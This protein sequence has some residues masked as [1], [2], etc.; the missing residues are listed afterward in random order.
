MKKTPVILFIKLFLLALP[1]ILS[2]TLVFYFTP[3]PLTRR[4]Q[5]FTDKLE[6]L[7]A[8]TPNVPPVIFAGDSRVWKGLIPGLFADIS[9]VGA[10]NIATGGGTLRQFYR[11]MKNSPALM[12]HRLLVINVNAEQVDKIKGEPIEGDYDIGDKE[13]IL[14]KPLSWSKIVDIVN[15]AD[16]LRQYYLM[17][18]RAFV[19]GKDIGRLPDQKKEF[20]NQLGFVALHGVYYLRPDIYSN[21]NCS[22]VK[23]DANTN[24]FKTEGFLE[25]IDSLGSRDIE[26]VLYTTPVVSAWKNSPRS[27]EEACI[28]GLFADYVKLKIAKYKN[29]H[30]YDFAKDNI[31]GLND[32]MFFNS[33][34]LN[35]DG[36]K[37]FTAYLAKILKEKGL[38]PSPAP[39]KQITRKT[40]LLRQ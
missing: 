13:K 26:I 7:G 15:Y 12:N 1:A 23:I 35:E 8:M 11:T 22:N 27:K 30:F 3:D 2:F 33:D 34:H 37:F 32:T 18:L 19:R 38:I 29:F 39:V 31:P 21:K 16:Y 36:A 20:S 10:V 24:G 40:S 5:A 17:Q 28:N 6:A 14:S 25:A 4:Q 9:G